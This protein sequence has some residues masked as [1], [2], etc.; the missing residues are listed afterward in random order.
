MWTSAVSIDRDLL[1]EIGGFPLGIKSGEDLLVWAR[2]AVRTQW[3]FSMRAMAQYNFDQV[4]IK[5]PPTRIPE[6]GDVVGEGL[7]RLWQDNPE[8]CG[9]KLY[10]SLWHKMRS[11]MYM[12]LGGY[13]KECA[14][15]AFKALRY[16]P[17]NYKVYAYLVL[18]FLGVYKKQ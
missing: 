12:R 13:K 3:A 8:V 5:E 17:L 10:L 4:S 2:T 6:E 7:K 16:N 11:S 15:E 18:N 14:R 1:Q 9:L